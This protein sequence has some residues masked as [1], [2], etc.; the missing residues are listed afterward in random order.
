[1]SPQ[2]QIP[3]DFAEWII[4]A[5]NGEISPEQFAQLDR[6][7]TTNE[8]A[9]AYYLEFMATYVGL[10]DL[11]GGLPAPQTLIGIDESK[12]RRQASPGVVE[13]PMPKTARGEPA[14]DLRVGPQTTEQDRI[15]EIERY[16]NQQLAAF[17]AQEQQERSASQVSTGGWDFWAAIDTIAQATQRFVTA[18]AKLVKTAAVCLL[19]LAA[20]SIVALYFYANRTLGALLDSADAKWAVPIQQTDKLRAGRMT[21]EEGYARIKLKKGAEVILQAPSTFDLRSTNRMFLESGWITAKVPPSAAGF[22]VNTPLS[23]IVDFGTEFGLLVGDASNTEIHVFDGKVDFEYAGI[24]GTTRTRQRLVENE[25]VTVDS[26]GHVNWVPLDQ[27]PHLFSRMMP[28]GDGFGIPGKRLSLADM[29]GGGNGLDTG[30]SGQ[31]IDPAT[32][33]ITSG[34]KILGENDRGFAPTPSLPFIDG[35]F[36]PDSNDGSAIVTSTGLSFKQCPKTCGKCY[37][38]IV[39]GA[40]FEVGRSG[41]IQ[42]GRLAGR[43]YDTKLNP[44]LGMHP[45]AGITFDL[46]AIRSAMPEAEIERFDALCGVSE[47]VV[48]YAERDSDPNAIEVTFWV[49][50]DGQLRFSKKLGAVPAQSE[51]IRVP[52]GPDDRFLTL[53]TTRPGEY[54]YCWGMFAEP[55]LQLTREKD[56]GTGSAGR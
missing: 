52:I 4:R 22:A 37:E 30:V 26:L 21:L 40:V 44:S 47:T 18:G 46:D 24:V 17:L 14:G 48:R 28:R 53:A 42:Y 31:G 2:G 35:V 8:A 5:L 9:R 13:C 20:L 3:S 41:P 32:G 45:N 19:V 16:A 49:L 34:H 7:I 27:R 43:M 50:V 15:R 33:Q 10:V 56:A 39:D 54:R 6:E 11:I 51:R 29:V 23:S 1:M 36:V 55:A 12:S 38:P 25:A